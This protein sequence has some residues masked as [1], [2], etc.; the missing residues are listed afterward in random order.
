MKGRRRCKEL[1]P[2]HSYDSVPSLSDSNTRK[3]LT[4]KLLCL[5][6]FLKVSAKLK[7]SRVWSFL[8]E[9]VLIVDVMAVFAPRPVL[10]AD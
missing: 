9:L 3:L 6:S 7:L 8:D 4:A 1:A 5:S 10:R 2:S